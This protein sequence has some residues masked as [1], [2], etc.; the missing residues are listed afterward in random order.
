MAVTVAANGLSIIHK[1]SGGEASAT[2]PDVCLTQVG[3]AVVPIP[4]GNSAK[5]K[6]LV[7]GTTTI[8]MDGGNPVAI[9]GSSFSKSTGDSGGNKKGIASGTIE[10]EAKFI[11]AS[12]TVKFE[13]K[14]V[15]RLSDQMTMNK[16]NTLCLGGAQ[17]PSV[18]IS[19]EEEGTYSVD[20]TLSYAD[21]DPVQGAT[22]TLVDQTGSVFEGNLNT[23]GKASISGIAPGEF[24]IEYGEDT[25]EFS[26]NEPTKANPKYNPT[27]DPQALLDNAKQGDIGFWEN[28]WGK[29][30]GKVRWVWGVALGDFNHD[31]TVEQIIAN[32][33]ITM[34]PVVDQVADL[35]DLSANMINLLDEEARKEPENWLM[36]ALTL[37]GCIPLFGSAMKGT[38][39]IALKLGKETPK[40]DLL[41]VIR[42]CGKGDP[43]KFLRTLDWADYAKQCSQ[44]LSDVIKPC[45]EVAAELAAA[46][47]KIG[48]DVLTKYF[49]DLVDELKLLDKLGIDNIS[50]AMKSF[51]QLFKSILTKTDDVFPARTYHSA[52]QGTSQAGKKKTKV[53]EDKQ[54][55]KHCLLCKKIIKK[56][57]KKKQ[58]KNKD[59]TCVGHKVV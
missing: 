24:S 2:L 38:C 13:G 55:T 46:S 54:G 59:G 51:D 7:K 6:D 48:A 16:A 23:S 37:I 57:G 20:L 25:R 1:D 43:E 31:A 56:A 11:S 42:A 18:S 52:G 40:D 41:A 28:P 36:L 39:K 26:P 29:L 27:T 8:T 4:Y 44:I 49:T 47:D 34:I 21:G 14:G 9:K 10:G 5:S 45:Y 15:C 33:A 19:A 17:N 35:R 58:K 30:S 32:T 12:P 53:N 22:Y 3:N 50:E